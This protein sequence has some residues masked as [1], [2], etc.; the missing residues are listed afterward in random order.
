MI[1]DIPI[2]KVE[3]VAMAILPQLVDTEAETWEV[4][5][6]NLKKDSLHNV[7]VSSNGYGQ[8]NDEVVR[9]S[10]LRHFFEK[11]PGLSYQKVELIQTKVFSLHNEYLLS[12]SL[13]GHLYDRRYTFLS[14]SIDPGN[15]MDVPLL[16]RAGVLID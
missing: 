4:Y 6:I 1:K 10:T 12:F 15:F 16:N 11:I 8:M 9:T 2:K 7:I 3:G 13:D 5:L 14:G